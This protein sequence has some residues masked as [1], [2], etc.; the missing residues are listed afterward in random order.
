M[1]NPRP[2][3]NQIRFCLRVLWRRF[4]VGLDGTDFDVLRFFDMVSLSKTTILP[5]R[6]G[7]GFIEH[8]SDGH[9]VLL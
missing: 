3:H 7:N 4:D 9:V 8:I 2:T 6:D 5:A 1:A